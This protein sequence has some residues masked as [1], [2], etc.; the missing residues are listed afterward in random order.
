MEFAAAP[1]MAWDS[2]KFPAQ[3]STD[4]ARTWLLRCAHAAQASTI[5]RAP[6]LE[7]TFCSRTIA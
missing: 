7:I 4:I 6:A 2:I 1:S 3:S 5:A